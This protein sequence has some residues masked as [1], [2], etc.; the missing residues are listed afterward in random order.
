MANSE[1]RA[2]AGQ[3]MMLALPNVAD[4]VQQTAA[5]MEDD[6]LTHRLPI[7]DGPTWG[8]I[9]KPGLGIEVNE[10]KIAQYARSLSKSWPVPAKLISRFKMN[11]DAAVRQKQL[12]H[13]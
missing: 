9:D 12:R 4:G 2:A 11:D 1:L 8:L 3:H 13:E 10:D 6:I 7:A 5:M